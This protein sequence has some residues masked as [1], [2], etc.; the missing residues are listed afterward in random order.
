MITMLPDPR[1]GRQPPEPPFPPDDPELWPQDD[2]GPE[3]R[4]TMG[5]VLAV[6]ALLLIF[7]VAA[8]EFFEGLF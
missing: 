3:D 7:G 1:G 6:L 5:W 4:M 2:G 8:W